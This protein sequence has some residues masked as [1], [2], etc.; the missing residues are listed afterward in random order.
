MTIQSKIVLGS[1]YKVQSDRYLRIPARSSL[2]LGF[3]RKADRG[4]SNLAR[5]LK[6]DKE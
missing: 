2:S 5:D 1:N 4:S 3:P 6:T